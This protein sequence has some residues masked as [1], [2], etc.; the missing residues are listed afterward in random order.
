MT[1]KDWL[2]DSGSV[3]IL[4]S[5]IRIFPSLH[6]VAHFFPYELQAK[7]NICYKTTYTR[8]LIKKRPKLC[9]DIVLLNNRIQ[10]QGNNIY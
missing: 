3:E 5:Y 7:L 10:T 4:G 1:M 9:N 6:N 2:T 8:W